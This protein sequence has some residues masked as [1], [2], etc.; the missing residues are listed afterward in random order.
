MN[1]KI[2]ILLILLFCA[3]SFS[4][5][6]MAGGGKT[7]AELVYKLNHTEA[8][9]TT[10]LRL[11]YQL[12]RLADNSQLELYYVN[13]LMKD[14]ERLNHNKYKCLAYLSR[15]TLAYNDYNVEEVN[16]WMQRLE[17]IAES[18]KF[19][20]L[21]FWG[22]RCVI[23]MMMV[24]GEY[25][26][27]EKEAEK[28]LQKAKAVDNKIGIILAYQCLSNVYG[29]TYRELES[30]KKKEEAYKVASIYDLD[31]SMEI[32]SSL[33]GAY[34]NLKDRQN[35]LKWMKLM[36]ER[37]QSAIK[38]DP[39][40]EDR[41]S[42]WISMNLVAYLNYYTVG[43]NLK[44]AAIYLKKLDKYAN[45]G[46]T[47]FLVEYHIARC[48]Y[49][50]DAKLLDEALKEADKLI[51][52]YHKD[53]S[54]KPYVKMVY[55]KANILS[56]MGR[57][58][59]AI[60]MY[61]KNLWLSDSVNV[62]LLNK[63]A[64]QIKADYKTDTLLLEK[65]NI[66]WY[67]QCLFL[68]LVLTLIV[69]LLFFVFHAK[70]VQRELKKAEKD[71]RNMAEQMEQANEAKD[72]F[73]STI[74]TSINIPL[75]VVVTESLRLA[76]D[77]VTDKEARGEI[78]QKV[79]KT[80][81]ELMTLINNILNLSKLEAGMMRFKDED[82]EIVPC[83]QSIVSVKKFEGN[84]VALTSSEGLEGCLVHVDAERLR[85]VF[86][87]LL[88]PSSTDVEMSLEMT[89]KDNTDIHFCV[90]G[91]M[92]AV[93]SQQ[94]TQDEAIGNEVV[95]LLIEHFG[96][97]FEIVSVAMPGIVCFTLPVVKQ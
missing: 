62:V 74:S 16:K 50:Y 51:R 65:E 32:N 11:C 86:N 9:D 42:L 10:R 85:D 90:T 22:K 5:K 48:N 3:F 28:M 80:S 94:Q 61:Q 47:T 89:L 34:Q 68:L 87:Y 57:E 24:K 37:I 59:S 76:S 81:A 54:L 33:V 63:Q 45:V 73:L 96:G 44:E 31:L 30:A 82:L 79:N 78:S 20:D 4:L 97:T 70:R 35:Q 55:L 66:H 29:I 17:P 75:N 40:A 60:S 53:L 71:M 56:M 15:M 23:D 67:M 64:E 18:H 43:G 19:Y 83:V 25:E 36:D 13:L 1:N 27:E 72:K 6:M 69:I 21:L 84:L 88:V 92:L 46:Y 95:R 49:F 39:S 14:A 26:R 41:Y 12:I 2:N 77:E 58:D 93:H 91:T 8:D 38:K 7:K 52:I